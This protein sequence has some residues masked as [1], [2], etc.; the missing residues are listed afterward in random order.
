MADVDLN[1]AQFDTP[2]PA[3]G[4]I[5]DLDSAQFDTPPP[6]SGLIDNIS[7]DISQATTD[8]NNLQSM[9]DAGEISAP[10]NAFRNMGRTGQEFGSV[11]GD[12]AKSIYD[13]TTTDTGKNIIGA[14]AQPV[15]DAANSFVN[16]ADNT[17]IGKSFNGYMADNP[18]VA[19]MVGAV[20]GVASFIAPAAGI[21]SATGSIAA[22]ALKNS[23]LNV[24]KITQLQARTLS[25]KLYQKA[26]DIGATVSPQ[27]TDNKIIGAINKQTPQTAAGS[28][29]NQAS[30]FTA[31]AQDARAKLAGQPQSLTALQELDENLSE[32]IDRHTDKTTGFPTADAT[33]F[34][35]VQRAIR[36][37]TK[38]ENLAAGDLTA[39]T[40]EALRA[41]K[42]GQGVWSDS[43]KLGDIERINNRATLMG[44][45]SQA[46][47]VGYRR[48]AGSPD[49]KSTYTPAQQKLIRQA[50]S[51]GM[52]VRGLELG[53]Y[54]LTAMGAA[55]SGGAEGGAIGF[56][57]GFP[58]RAAAKAL[59]DVP[60][61]KLGD[62]ISQGILDRFPDYTGAQPAPPASPLQQYLL[63][64]PDKMSSL[65]MTDSQIS[66]A[67]ARLRK[68]AGETGG[69]TVS[70]DQSGDIVKRPLP[71]RQLPSPENMG[72]L[73]ANEISDSGVTRAR[74]GIA[75]A[76]GET[77]GVD[78]TDQTATPPNGNSV[79]P[80]RQAPSAMQDFLKSLESHVPTASGGNAI[81]PPLDPLVKYQDFLKRHPM[82]KKP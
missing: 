38:P 13:N 49:F 8:K 30:P 65:P 45:P 51:K 14:I 4:Q 50:A 54:G 36:G 12:V 63:A 66:A 52:M 81:S 11:V 21:E 48:L 5:I 29:G 80:V 25:G 77:G 16:Y 69:V 27:F 82:G 28:I 78:I 37:A 1:T 73:P 60:A 3:G 33:P 7:D 76:S 53:G 42:D 34:M 22:D 47:Q 58:L 79:M 19:G 31:W 41:W 32:H 23:S 15:K 18:R 39:G 56:G 72:P 62:S 71:T 61:S 64:A 9:Q 26:D 35:N 67:Q 10:E 74:A 75:A 70:P 68:G 57:A 2:H 24:P 55:L 6:S 17:D 59:Q 44:N 20:P 43:Y 40:P 46:V